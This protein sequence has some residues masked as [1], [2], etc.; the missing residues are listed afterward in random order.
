MLD[1]LKIRCIRY[2][3]RFP[4]GL[5][6]NT[7]TVQFCGE[8]VLAED[9]QVNDYLNIKNCF[10]TRSLSPGFFLREMKLEYLRNLTEI[11]C[12]SSCETVIIKAC[13]ALK[14]IKFQVTKSLEI[15]ACINFISLPNGLRLNELRLINLENLEEIPEDV[16]VSHLEV[17]YCS[18]LNFQDGRK[19]LRTLALEPCLLGRRLEW[20]DVSGEG[21]VDECNISS[22]L[23]NR[24]RARVLFERL[25]YM[26]RRSGRF[27]MVESRISPLSSTLKRERRSSLSL[28]IDKC[29][30][31]EELNLLSLVRLQD[32]CDKYGYRELKSDNKA[33]LVCILADEMVWLRDLLMEEVIHIAATLYQ[34]KM[35]KDDRIMFEFSRIRARDDLLREAMRTR[36]AVDEITHTLNRLS[37][38]KAK[39]SRSRWRNP[40]VNT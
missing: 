24:V 34:F 8:A 30:L 31:E 35:A 17:S 37:H 38:R 29:V 20:C 27:A 7:L 11:S 21:T 6:T 23:G 19:V 22:S 36:Y 32:L 2:L 15:N 5:C 39:Y 12:H 26:G 3:K 25:P 18:H 10:K 16:V 33:E 13:N 4:H 40:L 9:V 28:D 14:T 1:S